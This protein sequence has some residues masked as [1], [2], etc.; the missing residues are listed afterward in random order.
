MQDFEFGASSTLKMNFVD[1]YDRRYICGIEFNGYTIGY[2]GDR[3]VTSRVKTWTGLRLVSDGLGFVSFLF[4]DLSAW[5]DTH[6]KYRLHDP[7]PESRY[8]EVKWDK[9]SVWGTLVL[10][11]DVRSCLYFLFG[12][13]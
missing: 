5:Q 8:C 2:K 12:R 6:P 4:R 3:S 10:S 13:D 9:E 7:E 11:L 1:V